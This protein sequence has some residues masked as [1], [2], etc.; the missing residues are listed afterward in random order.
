MTL[1]RRT[2]G[3]APEPHERALPDDEA[4]WDPYHV[5]YTRV[6]LPRHRAEL[7]AGTARPIAAVAR[8]RDDGAAT[9]ATLLAPP[10][11]PRTSG[12]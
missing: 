9:A 7:A 10:A 5:W 11:R 12:C 1:A 2:V 3:I 6:L 4:G 8:A